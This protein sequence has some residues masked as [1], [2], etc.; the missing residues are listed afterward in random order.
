[1]GNDIST[2]TTDFFQRSLHFVHL[3]RI[4]RSTTS[5]GIRRYRSGSVSRKATTSSE[6]SRELKSQTETT[7]T[8]SVVAGDNNNQNQSSG[9]VVVGKGNSNSKRRSISVRRSKSWRCSPT[10]SAEPPTP[11]YPSYPSEY[12]NKSTPDSTKGL[13]RSPDLLVNN[14]VVGDE[15]DDFFEKANSRVYISSA[16]PTSSYD[17]TNYYQQQRSETPPAESPVRPRTLNTSGHNYDGGGPQQIFLRVPS[18]TSDDLTSSS[19]SGISDS[20]QTSDDQS[21]DVIATA[22]K[23]RSTKSTSGVSRKSSSFRRESVTVRFAEDEL[24][25]INV[26]STSQPNPT[27][28]TSTSEVPRTSLSPPSSSRLSPPSSSRTHQS[29]S[30]SPSSASSSRTTPSPNTRNLKQSISTTELQKKRRADERRKT[31]ATTTRPSTVNPTNDSP[32]NMNGGGG[33]KKSPSASRSSSTVSLLTPAQITLIRQHWNQTYITRG[34]TVVGTH[35]FQRACFKVPAMK[36]IFNHVE[37][38]EK[39]PNVDLVYKHH[40]KAV[41][42]LIDDIVKHLDHLDVVIPKLAEIGRKHSL[43]HNNGFQTNYWAV[44]AES[45]IDCTLEWGE[46]IR[47]VEEARKAWA[48]LIAY[49]VD[50]MKVGFQDGKRDMARVKVARGESMQSDGCGSPPK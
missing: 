31:I 46:K 39:L 16:N 7:L 5:N 21:Y 28:S 29:H 41:A 1:M 45:F 2:S 34:P 47:R 40:A 20:I 22:S 24:Q 8:S 37:F 12:S 43:Y 33:G 18:P 14:N 10:V 4:R 30:P 19:Y 6:P 36:E 9:S 32:T 15:F 25:N 38:T 26:M 13:L 27:S 50:R 17:T 35:V 11:S 42:L 44:F 48:I 49:I 3:D 23:V